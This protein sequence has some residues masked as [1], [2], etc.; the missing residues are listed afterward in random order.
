[1]ID[2]YESAVRQ[3]AEVLPQDRR[4]SEF[5]MSGE[6]MDDLL[7]QMKLVGGTS[8]GQPVTLLGLPVQVNDFMPPGVVKL[9]TENEQERAIRRIVGDGVSVHVVRFDW[10]TPELPLPVPAPTLRALLRH[11]WKKVSR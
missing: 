9:V 1:M 6:T 10:P 3:Y 8:P 4:D 2:I 7:R 11:W 5:H